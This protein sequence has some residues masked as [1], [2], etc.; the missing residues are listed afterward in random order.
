MGLAILAQWENVAESFFTCPVPLF[1]IRI[2][3]EKVP[4]RI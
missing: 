1:E 4:G 3:N 2:G